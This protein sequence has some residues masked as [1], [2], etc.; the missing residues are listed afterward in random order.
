MSLVSFSSSNPWRRP[1]WRW[2]RALSFLDEGAPRPS[3][4]KD[5]PSSF[6]WIWKAIRFLR[7]YR[8]IQTDLEEL[9]LADEYPDLYWSYYVYRNTHNPQKHAIEAHVLAR[10]SDFDIAQSCGMA[11]KIIEAYESLFFD[12][13]ARLHHRQYILHCVIG[14]ELQRSLTDGD[15]AILWKLYGYFLGPHV[16]SA[17]ESK[18]PTAIWC[19]SPDAVGAA[20]MDDAIS[21]L[22]LKAALAAKTIPVDGRTQ[23][24]L[25]HAFT[26]FVEVERNSDSLGKSQEQLLDH[27]DA[28]LDSLPFNIGGRNPHTNDTIDVGLIA[29][30]DRGAAEL[31][32]AETMQVA[33]R[34]PLADAATLAKL[35]FPV[36]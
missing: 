7:R 24:E 16:L 4:R 10:D 21:T 33:T 34:Q 22:K 35:S 29:E 31:T 6:N 25:L 1:D 23:I 36:E 5:G 26:K 20:V 8:S 9:Q 32:Y 30:Y 15:Y 27:V 11:T 3:R 28:M 13:R 12:V 18:F 19:G 2:Q 14:P 17:L